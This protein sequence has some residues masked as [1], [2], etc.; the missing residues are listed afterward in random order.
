M[1][2]ASDEFNQQIGP[3]FASSQIPLG[4]EVRKLD[5]RGKLS[6]SRIKFWDSTELS[7][8]T[9]QMRRAFPQIIDLGEKPVQNEVLSNLITAIREAGYRSGV[10]NI[11]VVIGPE[12]LSRD[13]D[14]EWSEYQTTALA[15]A[16]A[17]FNEFSPGEEYPMIIFSEPGPYVFDFNI[18]EQ[19]IDYGAII[20]NKNIDIIE[21]E[22]SYASDIKQAITRKVYKTPKSKL[23][24]G[25]S[26]FDLAT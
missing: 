26:P 8:I 25:L 22:Q 19:L 13:R 16:Q 10:R 23:F 7:L 6:D 9:P 17:V 5:T 15:I 24:S 2:S 21:S 3:S 20:S 18:A 11:R 4:A 1:E 14:T 12:S